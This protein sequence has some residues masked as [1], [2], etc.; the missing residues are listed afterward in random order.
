MPTKKKIE[1]PTVPAAITVEDLAPDFKL[2]YTNYVQASFTPL[3][4]ALLVGETVG[5]KL[6]KFMVQ[7]KA[8]IT[9]SP[10]EAKIVARILANTVKL[11]EQQFGEIIVPDGMMPPEQ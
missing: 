9:M 4:V 1:A 8:R 3:D 11:F 2:I 6:G 7:N 5:A 10:T